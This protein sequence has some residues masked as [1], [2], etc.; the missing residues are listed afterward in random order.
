MV[1]DCDELSARA[2]YRRHGNRV[3]KAI[4]TQFSLKM[5]HFISY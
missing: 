4:V 5:K 1:E 3:V 2:L